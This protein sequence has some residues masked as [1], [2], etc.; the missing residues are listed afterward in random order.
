ML[1]NKINKLIKNN[2][3]FILLS[4]ILFF[5]IISTNY[6]SIYKKNQEYRLQNALDNI[7]FK[8]SINKI[9]ENLNPK[10]STINIKI[11][12]GDTFEKILNNLNINR[13][14]KEIIISYLSKFK[15]INKLYKGQK[16]SFKIENNDPIKVIGITIEK[17]K[18]K[19]YIFHRINET[20]KFEYKEI[21]KNLKRKLL[22]KE[23]IILRLKNLKL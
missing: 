9:F 1:K 2:I 21:N 13:N 11:N 15:F 3:Y 22:L 23:F 19:K 6:Y 20:N 7:F 18:T 5:T 8:K 10:F 17:S 4:S 14:E 12:Q 16:I